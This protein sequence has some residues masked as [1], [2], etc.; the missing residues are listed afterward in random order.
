MTA[1]ISAAGVAHPKPFTQ[2]AI[3]FP[4]VAGTGH[5][6]Q[7][8]GDADYGLAV[9]TKSKHRNAAVT[10]ATWLGTSKAGQ[11]VVANV[12]NDIP[13]LTSVQPDWTAAGL[14]NATVQQP[15]LQ[16]LIQQAGTTSEPRLA[17]VSADLQTAIGDATTT[18]AGGKATPA[19]AAQTLES[20]A[21]KLR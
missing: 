3:P 19:K 7:I 18:V 11:Q 15:V 1:A 17:T 5:T 13:A 14:V 21:E 6:G 9:N 2:L 8:F 10:F 4:D 12:L 16:K 20:A